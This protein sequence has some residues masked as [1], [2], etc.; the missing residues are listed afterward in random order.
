MLK[1]RLI[2]VG[3]ELENLKVLEEN[4]NDQKAKEKI[5]KQ[6]IEEFEKIDVLFKHVCYLKN[7]TEFLP[8]QDA[9]N[10]LK[11]VSRSIEESRKLKSSTLEINKQIMK[12]EKEI[13]DKLSVEWDDYYEKCTA[14]LLGLLNLIKDI[15]ED[16]KRTQQIINCINKGRDFGSSDKKCIDLFWNGLSQGQE[17]VEEMELK[18]VIVEFLKKV[19]KD[20]VT[21]S[22]LTDEIFQWIKEEKIFSKFKIS[23]NQ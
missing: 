15:V 14:H 12:L 20:V 11:N 7:E 9:I 17:I 19:S 22:D 5:E 23:F 3:K 2:A 4:A 16:K 21:L 1:D 10:M 13:N 8:S 6:F 18:P